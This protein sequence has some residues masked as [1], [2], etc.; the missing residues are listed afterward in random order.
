MLA[1]LTIN[2]Y[3]QS[4]FSNYSFNSVEDVVRFI[5]PSKTFHGT[6]PIFSG[7]IEIRCEQISEGIQMKMYANNAFLSLVGWTNPNTAAKGKYAKLAVRSDYRQVAVILHL[8]D[9]KHKQPYLYFLPEE[10]ATDAN[11]AKAINIPVTSGWEWY[12]PDVQNGRAILILH[13]DSETKPTPIVY[14]MR[15]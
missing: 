4:E 14:N 15:K 5:Y 9:E 13:T 7:D 1:L 3:A 10:T 2:V 12:E 8:P 11:L 6:G